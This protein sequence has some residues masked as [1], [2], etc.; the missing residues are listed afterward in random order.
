[1]LR[2]RLV[3]GYGIVAA[4]MTLGLFAC[5]PNSACKEAKD[6]KTEGKCT[7]NEAGKC[8]AGA[9]QDCAA[10]DA[11]RKNG[12]CSAVDDRCQAKNDADITNSIVIP[13]C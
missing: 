9:D 5:D 11:C 8:I 1:M 3:A 6:C 10:S 13:G 4:L 12:Q 7:A 2:L